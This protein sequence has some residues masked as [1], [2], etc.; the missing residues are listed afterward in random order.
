MT[1]RQSLAA[2]GD[3]VLDKA[4]KPVEAG[5]CFPSNG[6][7]CKCVPNDVQCHTGLKLQRYNYSCLGKCNRPTVIC[8]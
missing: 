6:Q 5:A 7:L 4:L 1:F 8:C 2:F 3:H